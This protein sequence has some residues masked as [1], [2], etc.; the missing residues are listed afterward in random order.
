MKLRREKPPPP[1]PPLHCPTLGAADCA[2]LQLRCVLLLLC[3]RLIHRLMTNKLISPHVSL[4]SHDL[5][6]AS[7]ASRQTTKTTLRLQQ[8]PLS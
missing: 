3:R 8:R 1:Q 5:L 2:V 6:R 7:V 4:C